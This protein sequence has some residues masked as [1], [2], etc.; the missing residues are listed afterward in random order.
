MTCE[1]AIEAVVSAKQAVRQIK[2]NGHVVF[3]SEG[4]I[5][6]ECEVVDREGVALIERTV[7]EPDAEGNFNGREILGWLGY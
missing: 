2:A 7:F 1:D 3:M 6:A 5:V 4:K